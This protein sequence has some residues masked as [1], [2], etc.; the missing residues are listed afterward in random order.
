M[1]ETVRQQIEPYAGASERVQQLVV[2][3]IVIGALVTLGGLGW[4][5]YANRKAKRLAEALA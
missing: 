5:W 1:I 3:L 4:R 2:A